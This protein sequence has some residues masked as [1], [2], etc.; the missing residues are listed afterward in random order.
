MVGLMTE[1]SKKL[2]AFPQPSK[3]VSALTS[4]LERMVWCMINQLSTP[5]NTRIM[6][7]NSGRKIAW[8]EPWDYEPRRVWS[9][10]MRVDT[11]LA[12][13]ICFLV[14]ATSLRC[15]PNK[16]VDL[17]STPMRE[18]WCQSD[19]KTG[20]SFWFSLFWTSTNPN[21]H[22]LIAHKTN[23]SQKWPKTNTIAT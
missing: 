4:F 15:K 18:S 1:R 21:W 17:F 23:P 11:C 22:N 8:V 16:V 9:L 13:W 2:C 7:Y 6:E 12:L 3:S 5:S 19:P 10:I 14:I 20:L